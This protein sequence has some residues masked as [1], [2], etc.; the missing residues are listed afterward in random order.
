MTEIHVHALLGA[1]ARTGEDDTAYSHRSSA[2]AINLISQW[3]NPDHGPREIAW[4]REGW[5]AIKPYC[6]GGYVNFMDAGDSVRGAYGAAKF[7][8]LVEIKGRYDPNNIFRLNQN[9]EPPAAG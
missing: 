3:E 8:R 6:A 1:I 7:L 4:A 5:E 2:Y 9:I